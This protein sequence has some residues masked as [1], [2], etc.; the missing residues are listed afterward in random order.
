MRNNVFVIET[1]VDSW[2][3]IVVVTVGVV[4]RLCGRDLKNLQE[5]QRGDKD[6]I[7]LTALNTGLLCV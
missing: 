3:V 1:C 6:L 4:S 2:D 7:R 5:E